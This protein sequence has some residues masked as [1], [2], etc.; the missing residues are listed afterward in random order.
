MERCTTPRWC[1][2]DADDNA[3]ALTFGLVTVTVRSLVREASV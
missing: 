2:G 3:V 1:T